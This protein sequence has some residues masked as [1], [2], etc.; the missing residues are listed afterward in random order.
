[1][2]GN[3]TVGEQ[4]HLEVFA[5]YENLGKTLRGWFWSL[6]IHTCLN[7]ILS[8]SYEKADLLY[9]RQQ[10]EYDPLV[11]TRNRLTCETSSALEA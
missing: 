1:M 7:S 5:K 4:H 10:A 3:T 9:K 6:K 8:M 2:Y 11:D